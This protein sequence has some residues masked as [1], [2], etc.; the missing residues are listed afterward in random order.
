MD[1]A[2]KIAKLVERSGMKQADIA[3]AAGIP[4]SRL[5]EAKNGTYKPP[6][7]VALRLARALNVPLDYLADDTQDTPPVV[8]FPPDLVQLIRTLGPDRARARLL[9]IP[10]PGSPDQIYA[11]PIDTPGQRKS[12]GR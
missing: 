11:R 3:R 6:L 5:T 12:G 4:P 1:M 7:Q 10:E 2:T 9:Q 8:E